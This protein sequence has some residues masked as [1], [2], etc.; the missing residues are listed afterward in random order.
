MSVPAAPAP[1]ID[2]AISPGEWD[3]ARREAF[4]D[5]SELLLMSEGGYLYLAIRSSTPDMIVGNVHLNRG[6]EITILHTSAALGTAI[7]QAHPEGW[8]LIK[9]FSWCCRGTGGSEADLTERDTFLFEEGW[10]SVNSRVGTPNELEYQIEMPEKMLRIAVTILR[11]TQTDVKI[12][13]PAD[14]DDDCLRPTPGGLPDQMVYSP[15]SWMVV[16]IK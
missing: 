12:P 6:D 14:L 10:G 7:Y 13:W 11:A 2:G 3:Q 9:P 8:E 1:T 16:A 4:A 15:D 5:G